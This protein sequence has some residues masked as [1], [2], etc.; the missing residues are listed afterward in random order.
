MITRLQGTFEG[1]SKISQENPNHLDKKALL[2]YCGKFESLDGPVEIKDEDVEKL[3]AN[4]NSLFSKLAEATGLKHCPPIQLDHSTSAKD[5]V[6]RLVG[7]LEVGAHKAEDG[8]E[9]KALYGTVRI[10]G[11]ENMEKV[12]DGRWTHLSIGADLEKHRISELTITPFPAAAEASLLAQFSAVVKKGSHMGYEISITQ[13]NGKYGY[14]CRLKP[15]ITFLRCDEIFHSAD[16]A[17][18]AAKEDI[19]DH[20]MTYGTKSQMSGKRLAADI[21]AARDLVV[22]ISKQVSSVAP[23]VDVDTSGNIV[24]TFFETAEEA[25]KAAALLNSSGKFRKVL[26][27]GDSVHCY[28][29]ANTSTTK[30]SEGEETMDYKSMKEK[31]AMYEKCKKHMGKDGQSEE[32][33]EKKLAEMDDEALS[34]MAADADEAEKKMAEDEEKKKKEEEQ[35]SAKM[36][37]HKEK[38]IQLRK[39]MK[40]TK[41]NVE[42]ATKKAG[43][44][45]RLSKLKADGKITP[46]EIKKIDI[47]DL[48]VKATDVVDAVLA[49]YEKREPVIMTGLL[50]T[51]KALTAAQLQAQVKKMNKTV[52]E[53]ETELNMPSKRD[54]ALKKLAKLQEGAESEVNIHVDSLPEGSHP[55]DMAGYDEA[56]AKCSAMFAEG[57]QN[58]AKEHLKSYFAGL[59]KQSMASET[60]VS[61]ATPHLSA[62]AKDVEKLHTE[63]DDFI[64]LTG[65]SFGMTEAE[66]A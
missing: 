46:A 35:L 50:G 21:N 45:T 8:Q 27:D 65:T 5:T 7:N 10:L 40:A 63:F 33:V 6:G 39:S 49:T 14:E 17:L 11:K 29:A 31:M 15:G 56:F 52:L 60:V 9:Y 20:E 32:E 54:A 28:L 34:K 51:T 23:T 43:L 16:G 12:Q 18:K 38:I 47:E 64:R 59:M 36:S 61:D 26:K 4:H 57:K 48:A 30:L 13:Y 19:E 2:V 53:L 42:L 24:S 44:Q 1:E 58:E 3:A 55:T 37:A 62:L 22:K 66:L 41:T 25:S